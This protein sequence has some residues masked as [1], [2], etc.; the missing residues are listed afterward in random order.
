MATIVFGDFEWDDEKEQKNRKKHGVS[1]EE[2]S[3][4]FKDRRHLVLPDGGDDPERYVLIGMANN[5][6]IL[7]VVHVEVVRGRGKRF[8]IISARMANPRESVR[9]TSGDAS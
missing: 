1:F 2:A 3:V 8:R 5:E 6:R 9:Y 4:A 7:Y